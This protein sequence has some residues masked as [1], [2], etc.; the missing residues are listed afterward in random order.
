[1]RSRKINRR[2]IHL[3]KDISADEEGASGWNSIHTQRTDYEFLLQ[4]CYDILL[5]AG[6]LIRLSLVSAL[7]RVTPKHLL[8]NLIIVTLKRFGIANPRNYTYRRKWKSVTTDL[9]SRFVL[10]V[11]FLEN[12]SR[13]NLRIFPGGGEEKETYFALTKREMDLKPWNKLIGILMGRYTLIIFIEF[14]F[15]GG[16]DPMAKPGKVGFNLNSVAVG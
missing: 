3:G 12:W 8:D 9:I 14:I 1:M 16:V 5:T 2:W 10:F 13:C 11:K 4:F 6:N 7:L 15:S